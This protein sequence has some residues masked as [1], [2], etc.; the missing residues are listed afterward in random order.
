MI[1]ETGT[2][3]H[4]NIG[5]RVQIKTK[6]INIQKLLLQCGMTIGKQYFQKIHQEF[7]SITELKINANSGRLIKNKI[8]IYEFYKYYWNSRCGHNSVCLLYE[9]YQN[10]SRQREI[11]LYNEYHWSSPGLLCI[12]SYT[13]LAFRGFRKRLDPGFYLWINQIDGG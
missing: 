6:C 12:N 9:Y 13:V 1:L 11:V 2:E 3:F 5:N 4:C 10:D 8:I 7:F